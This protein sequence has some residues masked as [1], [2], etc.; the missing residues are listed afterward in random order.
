[1][2]DLSVFVGRKYFDKPTEDCD[3]NEI[4]TNPFHI[5]YGRLP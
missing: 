5:C 3:L 1:M 4:L 2:H